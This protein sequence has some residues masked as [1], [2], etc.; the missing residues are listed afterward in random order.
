MRMNEVIL[1][2]SWLPR[3]LPPGLRAR[4]RARLSPARAL[5]LS[6]DPR[7]Q[8]RTLLGVAL[9]CRLLSAASGR[10]VE[11]RA[12]RYTRRGKPHVPGLP[13]FSIAHA[14]GWVACALASAGAVGIDI[15]PLA[16]RAALPHWRSVF[17][18]D[19]LAAAH[20]ARAALSIWTTKEAVLKAAGA[21]FADLPQV[22]VRGRRVRFGGLRWHC[23]A[24]R[25]APGMVARLVTAQP[26]ARLRRLSVPAAVALAT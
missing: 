1:A 5:R 13:E 6:V 9:A 12:L 19:E 16:R 2:Y 15:E 10:S 3:Q 18:A 20:S 11:P 24:P 25:L 26:V 4:W 14:G 23:R 7:A 21:A 8:S 22:S 17:D